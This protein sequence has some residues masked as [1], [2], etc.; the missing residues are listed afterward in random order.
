MLEFNNT[1]D[2]I[3]NKI[4]VGAWF[5]A[6]FII[7]QNSDKFIQPTLEKINKLYIIYKEDASRIDNICAKNPIGEKCLELKKLTS[8]SHYE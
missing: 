4:L 8:K 2:P 3:I 1:G 7:I 6:I 5:I